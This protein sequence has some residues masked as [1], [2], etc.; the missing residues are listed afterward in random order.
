M[1][2]SRPGW[3]IL[4]VLANFLQ[5]EG[6]LYDSSEEVKADAMIEFDK[7]NED[8]L[9]VFKPSKITKWP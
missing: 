2:K 4:R 8:N 7:K 6:F 9:K 3:K 1:G 5:L